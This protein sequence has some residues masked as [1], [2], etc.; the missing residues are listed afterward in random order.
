MVTLLQLL[1]EHK[2]AIAKAW[3]E[4]ALATYGSESAQRFARERDPFANPVGHSLR[5]GTRA[6]LDA[7]LDRK[8]YGE[9]GEQIHDMMKIRAVQQFEPSEAVGFVFRLKGIVRS[10]VTHGAEFRELAREL[11]DLDREID[12]I[13]LAAFDVYVECREQL[14]MLRI[15]ELKRQIPW[16]AERMNAQDPNRE[17]VQIEPTPMR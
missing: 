14:F 13:A 16:I 1:R 17:L 11:S 12:R 10:H 8:D 2:E 9:I 6:V 3:L 4:D 15:N 5:V 7:L